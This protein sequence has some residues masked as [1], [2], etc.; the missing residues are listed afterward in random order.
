HLLS[1]IAM[2]AS[3]YVVRWLVVPSIDWIS[4]IFLAIIGT[5]SYGSAAY[6]LGELDS[7]DYRYFRKMLNPQ[8]TY[9]YVVNE[10][11]GKRV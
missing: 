10:L 5:I 7:D 11:L 6:L 2:V 9:Q 8:D 4:L 3:M 1:A